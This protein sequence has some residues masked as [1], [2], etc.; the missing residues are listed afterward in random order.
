MSCVTRCR[1]LSEHSSLNCN[2]IIMRFFCFEF[3]LTKQNKFV[4]FWRLW[5]HRRR[6]FIEIVHCFRCRRFIH[7]I[8]LKI[9]E[10]IYTIVLEHF[11][12][13]ICEPIN[14]LFRWVWV[15]I[16]DSRRGWTDINKYRCNAGR[17]RERK[18]KEFLVLE[19][20]RLFYRIEWSS[21]CYF[22]LSRV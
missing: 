4:L 16:V 8:K 11:L 18:R 14:I 21:I 13:C 3:D 12:F 2:K 15:C 7:E 6:I 22:F 19:Q 9:L 10:W 20:Q 17:K 5:H 1:S